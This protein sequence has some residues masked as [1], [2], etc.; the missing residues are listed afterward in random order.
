VNLSVAK[1]L[2]TAKRPTGLSLK[3]SSVTSASTNG[4]SVVLTGN[5]I[6]YTP[7]PKFVGQ[8]LF[9]YTLDDGIDT[10]Q[11]IVTVTVTPA[12]EQSLTIISITKTANSVQLQ[13]AGIPGRKYVVQ[14]AASVTGPWADLSGVLIADQTGLIQFD[15]PSSGPTQFF[16][17]RSIAQNP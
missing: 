15:A 5:V 16:S 13:F 17:I 11:G 2:A 6:T 1:L 8:D 4:G 9:A 10:A 3:I 14:S 7:A 12:N